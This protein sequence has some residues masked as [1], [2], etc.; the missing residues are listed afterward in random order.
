MHL[1]QQEV[2][3]NLTTNGDDDFVI[4]KFTKIIPIDKEIDF[5]FSEELTGTA[6]GKPLNISAIQKVAGEQLISIKAKVVSLSGVK[7]QSTRYGGRQ[8][9]NKT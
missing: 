9:K 1:H 3:L 8:L 5:S 7:V 6:T 4:T 2:L